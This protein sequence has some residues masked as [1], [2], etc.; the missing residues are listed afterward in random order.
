MENGREGR[1]SAPE[2]G[3]FARRRRTREQMKRLTVV[4]AAA[5]VLAVLLCGF[6]IKKVLM[7]MNWYNHGADRMLQKDYAGA[8]EC[9]ERAGGYADSE[10]QLRLCRLYLGQDEEP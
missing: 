10:E 3:G 1:P 5:A 6:V 4:C 8:A 2:G 7:P 9:F